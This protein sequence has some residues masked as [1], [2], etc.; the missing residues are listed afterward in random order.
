M[1]NRDLGPNGIVIEKENVTVCGGSNG[2]PVLNMLKYI[3][4]KYD[5]DE[6]TY[7]DRDGN[8]IVSSY[9]LLLLAHNSIAFDSWVELNSLVEEITE[10]KAIKTARGLISLSFRC[11]VKLVNS[12]EVPQTV[13]F[14]CTKNQK[15]G[16]LEKIG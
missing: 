5:E 8:E 14:T 13:K 2:N 9:R 1:W 11:G 10:L 7:F 16:S 15:K 4:E 3:S 6:R 12:C